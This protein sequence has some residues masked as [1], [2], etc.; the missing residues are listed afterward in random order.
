[1]KKEV[2]GKIYLHLSDFGISKNIRDEERHKS[3]TNNVKGTLEYLSPESHL[4][5]PHITKQDVWA[6][7]VIAYELCTFK[8]PFSRD[9]TSDTLHAIIYEDP[10]PIQQDYSQELKDVIRDMLIKDPEQRHSILQLIQ[11]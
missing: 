10:S 1:L 6:I 4:K 2:N 3:S 11:E 8:L 7:G 5:N 9:T